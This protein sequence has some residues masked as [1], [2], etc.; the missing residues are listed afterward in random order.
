MTTSERIAELCRKD[1]LSPS[2]LLVH[3]DP[4]FLR[5]EVKEIALLL[6]C[7]ATGKKPCGICLA[8][9]KISSA[10]H[11]DFRR[12]ETEGKEIKIEAI[13]DLQRWLFIAPHEAPR[14][15]AHIESA[16]LLNPAA[17]NSLLKTLEEPPPYATLVLTARTPES[18]LP[19]LRSRLSLIRF[20]EVESASSDVATPDWLP[21]LEQLLQGESFSAEA[22]FE[23]TAEIGNDLLGLRH[24]FKTVERRLRDR[25]KSATL[26]SEWVEIDRLFDL[27]LA[28]ERETL[29]RYANVALSLDYLLTE[30]GTLR[31][32]S[33]A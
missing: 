29:R 26:P 4:L 12:I 14:K 33:H 21:S 25:M 18:L 32:T 23:L 11:P 5:G 15:M 1:R 27:A 13:R 8:C 7:S 9:K 19:T 16:E 31:S 30:L 10:I 20:P 22:V 6:F 2:L 17:S 28:M 3:P 24:F